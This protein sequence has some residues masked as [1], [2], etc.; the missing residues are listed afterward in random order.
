MPQSYRS[1]THHP[2][3]TYVAGTSAW[4]AIA[5]LVGDWIKGTDTTFVI[6]LLMGIAVAMLV[7]ISRWYIVALQNRIIRL[8][9]RVRLKEVLPPPQ[10][11][12]IDR[13]TMGQLV[14]LRFASDAELPALV[15]RA[16][17]ENLSRDAIKRAIADWQEDPYRT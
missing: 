17:T 11:D 8:E 7:A 14:A 3:P 1:H 4:A 15:T 10:H 9:M 16:T 2:V 12:R 5:L 6:L 13:L